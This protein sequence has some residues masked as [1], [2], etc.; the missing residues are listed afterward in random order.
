MQPRPQAK[1]GCYQVEL[2]SALLLLALEVVDLP[3]FS[4]AF[5]FFSGAAKG[6][7]SLRLA[8]MLADER[9]QNGEN[10][11]LLTAWQL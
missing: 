11:F 7:E 10:L 4:G 5:R 3:P 9:L 6:R 1:T 8:D 2:V